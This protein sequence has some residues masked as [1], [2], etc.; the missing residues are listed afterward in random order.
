MPKYVTRYP[1]V[2]AFKFG[3]HETPEWFEREVTVMIGKDGKPDEYYIHS[4]YDY[5]EVLP[6]EWVVKHENGQ[7]DVM[8]D[9]YFALNYKP[10]DKE[11]FE[12]EFA[13]V[14]A[15]KQLLED[16]VDDPDFEDW[17][18]WMLRQLLSYYCPKHA[19]EA[20]EAWLEHGEKDPVFPYPTIEEIIMVANM[21][22]G[23]H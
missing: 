21:C 23:E 14:D 16:Y 20:F 18:G 1:E 8:S 12:S 17:P 10:K 19:K 2:E 7:I 9:R 15:L 6:G 22:V 5:V 3:V 13:H 4:G 11:G